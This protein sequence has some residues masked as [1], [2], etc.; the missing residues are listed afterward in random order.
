MALLQ[1]LPPKYSNNPILFLL[2]TNMKRKKG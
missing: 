1:T 2:D